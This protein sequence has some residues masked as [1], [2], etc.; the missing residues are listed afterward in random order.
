MTPDLVL[1]SR[2]VVLPEGVCPASVHVRRGRILRV[3]E[4]R[5]FPAARRRF[6]FGDA[7]MLPGLVDT[8]VHINDPGRADW[9]GFETATR[10]AAAGGVTTLIEMPLNSVPATTTLA[11]FRRKC[12]S[13]KGLL[14]VDVGFWGGVVP[15][16]VRELR[17][18]WDAGVFGFKC[19]LVPSGV[20]EFE[21]VTEKDLRHA[22]RVLKELGA[23]L[24]AHAE[25]PGPIEKE[26]RHLRDADPRQYRTW[27][28]SRP[29]AA[30]LG[31][32]RLLI[33]LC[34]EYRV[35]THIV[36]LSAAAGIALVKQARKQGLPLSAETCPHYLRFRAEQIPDGA[37][38]FKCAPPIR[39]Q[40]N[41][42]RLWS[43]LRQGALEMVVTDHSPCPPY[44]KLRHS[45]DFLRA[46]GGVA[47]LELSLSVV[48]TE[49]RR[50]GFTLEHVA[51]WMCE[52]PAR[53][54]GLA[55]KGRIAPGYHADFAVF[56]PGA[57]WKVD[58]S[59][60]HQRHKLTPYAGETLRGRVERTFLRGHLVYDGGSFPT[61]CAGR[62]LK[63][64]EA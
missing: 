31:A 33:R 22:L 42:E 46:W 54:A 60:L 25:I 14:A 57:R 36:H 44:M 12:S 61:P 2:R 56:D 26:L 11:A 58:T 62:V 13:A 59:K 38:E 10:A 40:K 3:A 17:A 27:L 1:R 30:E 52:A 63:R 28:L 24:L 39:E 9:E 7:V 49:A 16:N 6:D 23:V 37:T 35:R 29:A 41:G 18:L 45:G 5:D 34:R 47:S 19:F 50:R 20:P 53:L 15:G 48:W 51:R 8:H 21:H 43:G 4:F 64:G 32:I 55:R